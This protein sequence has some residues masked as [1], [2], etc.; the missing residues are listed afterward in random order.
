M[1]DRSSITADT[2]ELL[3]LNQIAIRAGL[4]ELSLWIGQR[5]STNVH[6][7]MLSILQTLDTNAEAIASGIRSL[8]SV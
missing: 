4:E 3:H 5:G 8:R 2:L 7:N 6:D 1:D